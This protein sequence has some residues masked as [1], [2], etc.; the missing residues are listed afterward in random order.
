MGFTDG[1]FIILIDK[2]TNEN[3]EASQNK[4]ITIMTSSLMK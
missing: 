1:N 4:A 3:S 2:I